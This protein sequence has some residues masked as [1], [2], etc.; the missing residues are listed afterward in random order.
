MSLRITIGSREK[1][2]IKAESK[3]LKFPI[4]N[5]KLN[6]NHAHMLKSKSNLMATPKLQTTFQTTAISL[7]L[8][9]AARLQD[10]T[11]MLCM[12]CTLDFIFMK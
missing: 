1:L 12:L 6:S 10:K 2:S 11:F 7:L 3:L 9:F 5:T 4:H 8:Q